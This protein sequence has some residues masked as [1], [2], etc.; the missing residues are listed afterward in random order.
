MASEEIKTT[1]EQTFRLTR[2]FLEDGEY[3]RYLVR[4][5]MID[6]TEENLIAILAILRD[7]LVWIP[8]NLVMS[9]AD[10]SMLEQMVHDSGENEAGLSDLV[11]KQFTTNDAVRLIPDILQRDEEYFFPVFSSVEAMGEYGD[12]FSKV[13]KHMLEA[14][15]LARGNERHPGAI[16]LNAFSEAFVLDHELW[17][18]IEQMDSSL[19]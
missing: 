10:Q 1:E 17:G 9:A 4:R 2:E 7:S 5:F 6:R 12:H 16:V 13:Q 18:I 11:G 3:L 19:A 8:C 15:A 14:I